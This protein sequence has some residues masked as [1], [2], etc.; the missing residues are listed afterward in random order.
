MLLIMPASS[1]RNPAIR[2]GPYQRTMSGGISLPI[3]NAP[4]AGWLRQAST[5]SR[6]VRR[7]TSVISSESR[8]QTCSAQGIPTITQRL[9]SAAM[10]RSQR[11]G[12]VKSRRQL[13][14]SSVIRA[15]SRSTTSGAGN[16]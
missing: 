8:K 12:G 3:R 14:P 2:C 15:R 4:T 13:A 7:T 11:G 5:T 10:S 9:R 1:R 16:L 6:T